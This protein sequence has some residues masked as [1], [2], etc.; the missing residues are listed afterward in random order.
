VLLEHLDHE[1]KELEPWAA[2]REDTPQFKAAKTAVRKAHKGETGTFIAWLL[3]GSDP[4][5]VAAL[6]REIPGPVLS[7]LN[8]VPGRRYRH[9]IGQTW[10]P[11]GT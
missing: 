1:E 9:T 3:D 10:T 5:V 4:D 6:K 2:E 7:M 8:A 11:A